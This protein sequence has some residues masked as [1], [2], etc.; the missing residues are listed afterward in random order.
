MPGF[1][2]ANAR[3]RAMKSR[4]LPRDT[5]ASLADESDVGAM[6]NVLTQTPY[7]KAVELALVRDTGM[8]ALIRTLQI[9]MNGRLKK[10]ERFFTGETAELVQLVLLR[11]DVDNLKAVLRGLSQQLAAEE[12]LAATVSWG[13]WNSADLTQLAQAANAR[14]AIDLLA[15]WRFPIAWPLLALRVD[16]PGAAL[17]QMET[18]LEQWYI[19]EV[20][21]EDSKDGRVL[22]DYLRLSIDT[23][24]IMTMLRLVGQAGRAVFFRRQF[25]AS[26]PLPL[27]IG[28]GR[29]P[30]KLL[31]EA[32]QAETVQEA[33]DM[34]ASTTY[35]R[36]LEDGLHH[37][38]SSGRLSSFEQALYRLRLR[39]AASFFVRDP[40]GIG[41]FLGYLLLSNNEIAN[42]RRIGQGI[43]LRRP[44]AEIQSD[45][46]FSDQ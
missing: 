39:Q 13:T 37:Y 38:L 18:A 34:L 21:A 29:L 33:V 20:E 32:A 5:L 25:D 10:I 12:I 30:L 6:L 42:L 41:I 35:G 46:L 44:T 43:Y 27:F 19:Q 2:Y 40:L 11:Y 7:Q 31:V 28:P 16:Q 36:T 1:D 22:Q 26:D 4:L 17:W 23:A 14:E 8:A 45:L 3:L 15:T 24:N 9:D